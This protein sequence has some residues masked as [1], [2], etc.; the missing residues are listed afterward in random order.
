M[1]EQYFSPTYASRPFI[2]FS[3]AHLS[4]VAIVLGVC[5]LLAFGLRSPQLLPRHREI[6]RHSLAIFA[7]VN[8][9]AWYVWE[10]YSGLSSLA[11]SLP[12]QICTSATILCPLML[13]RRSYRLFELLYFWG[14][15]GASQALVT[16]DIGVFG[17]PHFVFVIFFTSHGSI[18][19]CVVFM[20][21]AE[22]YRPY[23][24]SLGRVIPITLSF[25]AVAGLANALTGGNYLF[26]ARKPSFPTL[27]DY[28][29]PWPWYVLSLIAIGIVSFIIVY[30]PFA[31]RDRTIEAQQ[32]RAP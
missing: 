15:A 19:V 27:I 32:V 14:L 1:F 7:I 2:L 25:L 29:G 9:I 24:S 18:L 20:L 6:V 22:G 16:P 17:F 13:W 4:A 26:V 3:T 23:W 5:I 28:L 10:W 11:F 12:I 8:L 21:V 30:L 31:L